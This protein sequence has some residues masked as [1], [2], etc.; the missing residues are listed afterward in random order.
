[1]LDV[2]VRLLFQ[3]VEAYG[4]KSKQ[5]SQR[6]LGESGTPQKSRKVIEAVCG[7]TVIVYT[8][9]ALY[10]K[11]SWAFAWNIAWGRI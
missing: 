5:A 7:R 6:V 9:M 8:K 3:N 4:I 2:A 1:M 10:L 11:R